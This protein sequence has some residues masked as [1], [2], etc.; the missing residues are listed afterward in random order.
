MTKQLL[1]S[2]KY[3]VGEF[4]KPG[5]ITNEHITKWISVIEEFP[6]KIKQVTQNLSNEQLQSTYR[7][8]GWTVEQVVHHC[9]DS[10][11]NS[12]IRFKLTLTE[13]QPTIRPYFEDRWAEL[14]DYKQQNINESLLLIDALHKRWTMLLK[15][16][17]EADLK[18]TFIHPENGQVFSLEENIGIYSWHCEHHL[19][20][21]ENALKK[22]HSNG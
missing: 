17:N 14:P 10:H 22:V 11:M 9:A 19:K 7:N 2:E 6:G 20:H 12:Y 8:N 1:E 3:P 5:K 13:D 21:I 15:K 18:R 16:L 4:V